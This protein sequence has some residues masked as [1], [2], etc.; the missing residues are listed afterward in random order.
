MTPVHTLLLAATLLSL[1]SPGQASPPDAATRAENAALMTQEAA[2]ENYYRV[3]FPD[4]ASGRRAAISLHEQL[5]ESNWESGHLIAQL[6]PD[7][8]VRL[9]GFGFR[10]DRAEDFIALHRHFIEALQAAGM[11]QLLGQAAAARAAQ[12]AR[13]GDKAEA[14]PGYSC[15]ETVEETYDAAQGFTTT[16]P[17]LASWTTVGQSWEETAG[18]GGYP[19]K[20]LK[21]TNQA[22][23]G[24]NGE[25]KPRLFIHA[26]MH[27]REY[28]T[29][30]LVLAFA[31]QLLTGYGVDADSTWLLDHHEI[32]LL[33]QTN[34]DGRKKAETGLSWR[35]NTNQAYCGANSNNRGADLNRNFSF[36]WNSTNGQGSSGNACAET[37]RGASASSE[38]ETQAVEA[39]VRSL[40]PDRRGPGRNDAAP[41]DT[42]GI[43]LDIHSYG[44]LL[45]WPWGDRSKAAPNGTALQ[46]LGRKLAY[47]NGH[48]PEQSIGL[49]PTDGTSDGVSYGELGVAAFTFELGTNFFQSCA[50]YEATIK[51]S[52]LNA[53]MYAAKVV[54]TPYLTAAGPDVTTLKLNRKAATQGVTAGQKVKLQATVTDTHYN[55]SNGT[56]PTQAI[57][58]A[59]AFIDLPPWMPGAVALPLAAADG[60][61]DSPTEAVVTRLKTKT[62]SPGK[63]MVFVRG[64]DADGND[65]PVTA[66]FLVIN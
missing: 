8:I 11:P 66:S 38:P 29:A 57:A 3:W 13:R 63:H 43:H 5:M 39:Y 25:A 40:W 7:D 19:L 6:S 35:K 23:T 18:L 54:R 1:T 65:G 17:T 31:R 34:P 24:P 45:L 12:A 14:I 47:F 49:Y 4:L 20:V 21:L 27:A 37:F 16:Y 48:T 51:P 55:N 61:F 26:A 56:E 41:T 22:T 33:L 62:L 15:Y 28:A 64:R 32:H 52:N 9:Q 10:I 59:E 46:T 2:Q 30:P 42:S 60:V 58:S 36:S 50:S 44:Q 53:L